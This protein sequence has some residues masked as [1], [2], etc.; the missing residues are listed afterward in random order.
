MFTSKINN[1]LG[2]KPSVTFEEGLKL[3]LKW[4]LSNEIW[5]KSVTS[6]DYQSYYQRQYIN[7]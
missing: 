4:Y 2:W 1:D 5:L 3:T 7:S 6:G